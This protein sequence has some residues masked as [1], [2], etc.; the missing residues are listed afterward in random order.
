LERNL[1]DKAKQLADFT[2]LTTSSSSTPPLGLFASVY[3]LATT[4]KEVYQYQAQNSGT[5]QKQQRA[6]APHTGSAARLAAPALNAGRSWISKD[7]TL[8]LVGRPVPGCNIT[9]CGPYRDRRRF[10]CQVRGARGVRGSPRWPAHDM[11]SDSCPVLDFLASRA[12]T[13]RKEKC[14]CTWAGL[15]V[16]WAA[17][18]SCRMAPGYGGDTLATNYPAPSLRPLYRAFQPALFSSLWL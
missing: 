4:V 8:F 18:L 13:V 10:H 3:L 15:W 12:G 16:W 5:L 1:G 9:P 17:C 11:F 2:K 6:Q 7:T 14:A